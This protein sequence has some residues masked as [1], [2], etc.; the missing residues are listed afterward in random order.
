MLFRSTDGERALAFVAFN[1]HASY[2]TA[3]PPRCL[4]SDHYNGR[5]AWGNNTS[6]CTDHC[7]ALLPT[8]KDGAPAS[9]NAFPGHW[10]KQTCIL[11]GA[12]CDRGP[13]PRAPAYQSRYKQPWATR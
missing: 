8:T 4:N 9:W 2:P 12:Y 11:L 13:A 10:G 6:T 7:L 3:C 1:S 5:L